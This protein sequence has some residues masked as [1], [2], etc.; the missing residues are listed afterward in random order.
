MLK[1]FPRLRVLIVG[2]AILDEFVVGTPSGLCRERPVPV[3]VSRAE[4][5]FPGGAANA[6]A[7]LRALGAQTRFVSALGF[8]DAARTLRKLLL[9]RDVASTW[10]VD[11]ADARSGRKRR[12]L[13]DDHYV[14]RVDD[15]PH[16]F[17][18]LSVQRELAARMSEAYDECDAVLVSDYGGGVCG[19]LVLRALRA[20]RAQRRIPLVV[21]ARDLLKY[22][23][24]E[25]DVLTPN[26]DEA[27]FA[28]GIRPAT[29]S[30]RTGVSAVADRL[31]RRFRASAVAITLGDAGV[32]VARDG[33]PELIDGRR[34][35]V[36]NTCGAGDSFVA[37]LTLGVGAG[38]DLVDAARVG[39]E[40]AAVAVAK[41][42]TATVSLAELRERLELLGAASPPSPAEELA[43]ALARLRTRRERGERIVFTNGVFDLLHAGH[44]EL[45]RRARALGDALVVALNS[46]ASAARIKGPNRPITEQMQRRAV[47]EALDCVDEVVTFDA[48]T[49]EGLIETVRP[50]VYV[51][52]DDRPRAELPE[53]AV[54]ERIGAEVVLL[55][56]VGGVTTSRI[57][58]RVAA[59][60]PYWSPL[61]KS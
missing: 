30:D 48:L 41:P 28:A 20:L 8:G 34:V 16:G 19:P 51:R 25:V 43:E 24:L 54:A 49:A 38:A 37:A 4:H 29:A 2:D 50:H 44:V 27:A 47:L 60:T 18:E 11:A 61:V 17:D 36:E 45:L 42:F 15:E 31:R 7:N 57:I 59:R 3:I 9:A 46:D 21:D 56:C 32:C 52:G 39:L 26:F 35:A 40:A 5:A 55:P 6:A 14:V 10:I 33:E 58:E 53:I 1:A 23:E 12:V 13:A 22:A